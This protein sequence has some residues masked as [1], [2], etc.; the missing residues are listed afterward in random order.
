MAN[1]QDLPEARS[2]GQIKNILELEKFTVNHKV[3][4]CTARD[5][6]GVHDSMNWVKQNLVRFK[7]LSLIPSCSKN[8]F[9]LN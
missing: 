5:G 9:C 3:I 4:G 6:D 2:A 7:V 1:K 8:S